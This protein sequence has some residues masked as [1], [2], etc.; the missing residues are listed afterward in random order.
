MA[1]V[2]ETILKLQ[3]ARAFVKDADS[4]SHSVAGIGDSA[5]KSGEKAKRGWKGIAKWAGG[6]AAVYGA[7]R[8]LHSAVD[9]TENLAKNTMAL[10]RATGMDTKASSAWAELLK[11]RGIDTNKFQV[12]MVKLSKTMEAAR[13]GNK[14]AMASL[15]G[16]G[17]SYEAIQTGDVDRV[18]GQSADAFSKMTN[19]AEKTA[20]AVTLFGKAGMALLPMLQGGSAALNE[21]LG[22]VDKYGATIKDT[23]GAKDMIAKQR[24][25]KIAMD[26]LKISLGTALMPAIE[27][28]VGVLLKVVSALSPVLRNSTALYVI[29]GVLTTAYTVL[30]VATFVSTLMQLAFNAALLLIPLAI[31]AIVAGV[32]ILYKKWK[33]FHNAVNNTF[34]WI[35]SHWQLLLAILTGPIGLAILVIV[36]NFDKIKRA[37]SGVW[38]WIKSTFGKIKGFISGIFS[39]AG[40]FVSGIG[41]GIA[42]WINAHTPFGDQVKVG[43]L[44]FR[45]PALAA[46]GVIRASGA[47]LVGEQ[48]PE[49]VSLPRGATVWPTPAVQAMGANAPGGASGQTIVTK[50][51]LDRRQ[52]AEAVGTYASD[53]IARR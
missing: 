31:I 47:A 48:G 7:A 1:N 39:G 30:K 4:A 6:T 15:Q 51:Y 12:G 5:E 19:P 42:D 18:I 29:L 46:G 36:K 53:R 32:I 34:D 2:V 26:G 17:V 50:V 35:K 22:M 49:I 40:D 41:R 38:S 21:Q 3:G 10:S 16:L 14:K 43:P 37:V 8:Y 45:I 9:T 11:V 25:M 44:K 27:A 24:E 20:G 13:G 28:F 23:E 33:W 52:I